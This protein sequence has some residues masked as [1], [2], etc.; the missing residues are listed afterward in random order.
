MILVTGATG[1]LGAELVVQLLQFENRVRCIKRSTSKTPFKLEAYQDKIEWLNAD[2][3]DFSALGNAFE[4]VDKVYHCAAIV[5]LDPKDKAKMISTNTEGTANVVN[6]CLEKEVKKLIHVSSIVALGKSK[7]GEAITEEHYWDAFDINNG[8]AISKYQSEMEVWRGIEE[9]L[10]AVIVNPSVIIGVDASEEGTRSIFSTVKNGLKFYTGGGSGFVDVFDV[11][12]SMI[13]LGNSEIKNE[14]F[15]IN[16][17]NL[18]FKTLFERI[19]SAF[20][21]DPPKKLAKPWMLEIAWRLSGLKSFL[22]GTKSSITKDVAQLAS[23]LDAYSNQKIK[24]VI[25]FKFKPLE[26]S[27]NEI[28]NTF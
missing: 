12:R 4:G 3:L 26:Q 13:F 11:S 19:A 2:V 1:F 17:E 7:N 27:I 18:S 9:G 5:S 21:M 16:T 24:G 23:N 6:L 28:V 20:K 8:Y 10:N 15:I 14:R 22:T 25:D